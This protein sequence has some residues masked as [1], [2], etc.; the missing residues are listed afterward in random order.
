MA[1]EGRD[2]L[3][4]DDLE[5][6]AAVGRA[7]ARA[8]M[9]ASIRS[10]SAMA[11]TSRSRFALDVVEDL[12]DAG[13]PVRGEGVDV[14]VGP[15]E[16]LGHRAARRRRARACPDPSRAAGSRSGQ[17]GEKTDH[18][19]SGASAIDSSIARVTPVMAAVSRARRVPSAGMSTRRSWPR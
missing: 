7:I 17:I 6:Q 8:A 13:R 18:H 9:A 11:M 5:A 1:A 4:D 19:C 2:L 12:E 14:E 10:W 15:S 3:A 16:A